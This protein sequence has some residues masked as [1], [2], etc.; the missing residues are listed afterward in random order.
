VL[1]R[2]LRAEPFDL[3][4]V[5]KSIEHDVG[6]FTSQRPSYPQADPAGRTRDQRHLSRQRH[7]AFVLDMTEL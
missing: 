1:H 2:D 7:H 5:A 6:P 4:G 3:R